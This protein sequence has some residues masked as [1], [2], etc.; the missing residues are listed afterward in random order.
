MPQMGETVTEG[1]ITRWLKQPG[2]AVAADE[3]LLEISTDKV[4]SE[5]PSPTAG[6][7]RRILVDEGQT[8][9]IGTL[10]AVITDSPDEVV[11]DAAGSHQAT[12]GREPV[13]VVSPAARSSEEAI[14]SGGAA[15]E[16]ASGG[17]NERSGFLSP[18][19]RRLLRDF[20]LDPAEVDG[21]G[22]LGRLSRDDVLA[23]LHRTGRLNRRPTD[24]SPATPGVG[25]V[26]QAGAVAPTPFAADS[27]GTQA[28]TAALHAPAPQAPAAPAAPATAPAPA[29]VPSM[30]STARPGPVVSPWP[31]DE[32]VPF[33][34]VRRIT[35]E[36]MVRS[37]ATSAHT[38]VVS[39]VDYGA[40][41][42]TR[43][44]AKVEFRQR[45]G[46]ALSYLPFVARAVLIALESFPRLNAAV[47]DDEL[48]IRRRRN[49]GI[50]VDLDHEGLVV[51]VVH[52]A[53][54]LSLVG[55]ARR[56][57]ALATA[58]RDR[59]LRGADIADGT[60]TI[61]NAGGFGT[62]LTAPVINQPQVAI[63]ST[64]GVRPTPA[65]VLRPD[66]DPDAPLHERYSLAVRP[67]G[68][69]ALS[70]DHRANDGAYAS[71]F[72]ALVKDLL[73]HRD[74]AHEL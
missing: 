18:S 55:L 5:I 74:W 37:L 47:G 58:A 72:L 39:Q 65:A 52:D 63:L 17:G 14:P 69:L 31:G 49:L 27:L 64:D 57:S 68:N 67:V 26:P 35:A 45:E 46:F 25:A 54:D 28:D 41:D 21:T 4:D 8:V 20:H 40:L 59:K 32:V 56:M 9:S 44:A 48:V 61:T 71:A 34:N 38:L 73:E 24:G 22:E 19:V 15:P 1:T 30:G 2:D 7:L 33:T 51:P 60:F 23:H 66:A 42:R 3:P 50:A 29:S 12:P 36:H 43:A 13:G 6:Y 53:D 16:G 10:L 11:D 62:F 70:F